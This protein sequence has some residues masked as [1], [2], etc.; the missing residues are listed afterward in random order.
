MASSQ[1]PAH[2]LLEA[3]KRL[4]GSLV[5]AGETR[6]QLLV[7]ELEEERARV[8]TLLL[9]I[10][11]SLVMLLLGLAV[12]VLL[13]AVFFWDSHRLAAMGISAGALIGGSLLLALVARA[14]ARRHTLLKQTLTQ[15]A[16]DR[17]LAERRRDDTPTR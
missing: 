5:A 15:L 8:V 9:L 3:V 7:V 6:L 11:A 16:T 1:G 4:L 17:E 14:Q 12:L 13:V 10:G 2:R